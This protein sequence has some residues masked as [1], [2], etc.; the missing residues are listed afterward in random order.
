MIP[1]QRSFTLNISASGGS[2]TA[3]PGGTATCQPTVSPSGAAAISAGVTL[4]VS[5]LPPE[6]P[7]RSHLPQLPLD[8]GN[9]RYPDHHRAACGGSEANWMR[10]QFPN[11]IMNAQNHLQVATGIFLRF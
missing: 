4:T 8:Q 5:G 3:V 9:Q 2:V 11:G 10:T 6:Q 1:N 7:T